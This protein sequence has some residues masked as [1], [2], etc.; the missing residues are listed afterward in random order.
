MKPK[1]TKDG[2]A[3]PAATGAAQQNPGMT[4]TLGGVPISEMQAE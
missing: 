3:S 1:T 4:L 2:K